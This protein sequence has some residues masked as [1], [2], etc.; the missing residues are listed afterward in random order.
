MKIPIGIRNDKNVTASALF[1]IA[2]L[3]IFWGAINWFINSA[4]LNW[5]GTLLCFSGIIYIALGIVARWVRL[6]AALFGV[7][8]YTA[9]LVFECFL[10]PD[11]SEDLVMISLPFKIPIVILLLVAVVSALKCS[12]IYK[13]VIMSLAV[14][15]RRLIF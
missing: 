5:F 10:S 6:P 14:A 15:L 9:F 2:A 13:V 3:L 7:A 8:L 4:E 12:R 11:N 1:D